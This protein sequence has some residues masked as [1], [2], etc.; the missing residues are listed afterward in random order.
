MQQ[1]PSNA[2]GQSPQGFAPSPVDPSVPAPGTGPVGAPGAPAGFNAPTGA[3]PPAAGAPAAGYGAPPAAPAGGYGL[4]PGVGAAGPPGGFGAPAGMAPNPYQA[5]GPG[6]GYGMAHAGATAP[7]KPTMKQLLF[8]F[9][10]RALRMHYWLGTLGASFVAVTII[11][12]ATLV[13]GRAGQEAVP[14][15][16]LLVYIPTLWITLALAV[17]RW[18]DRGKSGWWVFIALVPLI[19]GLWQLVECGFLEGDPGANAYGPPVA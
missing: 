4:A 13:L 9:E 17:K 18:H 6:G 7:V 3:N 15:I 1:P 16:A 2:W 14:F 19:G 10:G 8:S 12:L 11:V 5:P